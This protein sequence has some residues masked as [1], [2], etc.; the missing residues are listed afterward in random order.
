MPKSLHNFAQQALLS[1]YREA[2]EEELLIIYP[3]LMPND[4]SLPIYY[5]LQTL[6]RS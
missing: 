4:K 5:F 1:P 3:C 6:W 2:G